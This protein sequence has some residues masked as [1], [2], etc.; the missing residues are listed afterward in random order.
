MSSDH[1]FD[2]GFVQAEPGRL[3]P[4][5]FDSDEPE[6]D[7]PEVDSGN[8][9]SLLTMGKRKGKKKPVLMLDPGELEAAAQQMELAA[10]QEMGETGKP[11]RTAV[12][13]GLEALSIAE[14]ESEAS[15]SALDY[16]EED[17]WAE[18]ESWEDSAEY[19]ESDSEEDWESGTFENLIGTR[20]TVQALDPAEDCDSIA[21]LEPIEDVAPEQDHAASPDHEQIEPVDNNAFN[22]PFLIDAPDD[23]EEE[24]EEDDGEEDAPISSGYEYNITA[25]EPPEY[26]AKFAPPPIADTNQDETAEPV[27]PVEAAEDDILPDAAL[28]FTLGTPTVFKDLPVPGEADVVE[29]LAEP[30]EPMPEPA[31][32]YSKPDF[33]VRRHG[34][35]AR[36]VATSQPRKTFTDRM[37]TALRWLYRR[38]RRFL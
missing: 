2:D 29:V 30:A 34:L 27:M 17:D 38:V 35:R 5:S 8:Y 4:F 11:E 20:K 23:E 37:I 19:A 1:F 13:T 16:E 12:H 15:E 9:D 36:I 6:E 25:A 3:Q 31:L 18:D 10:A 14:P 28:P 7:E 21:S 32:I 24:E 22:A 33:T 26:Q